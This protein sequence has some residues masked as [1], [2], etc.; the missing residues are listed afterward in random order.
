MERLL[1]IRF[2]ILM[3]IQIILSFV[4][5]YNKKNTLS[6]FTEIILSV[7]SFIYSYY[8]IPSLISNYNIEIIDKIYNGYVV[9]LDII[10]LYIIEYIVFKIVFL[11][12]L[13][14][15]CSFSANSTYP[16]FSYKSI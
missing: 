4:L 5:I 7:L 14:I 8:I 12:R 9:T 1:L 2:S 16:A 15:N 6:Y 10:W 13:V 3:L 11:F